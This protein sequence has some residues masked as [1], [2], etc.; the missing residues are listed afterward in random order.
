MHEQPQFLFIQP[1]AVSMRKDMTEHHRH[2]M[3]VCTRDTFYMCSHTGMNTA[4]H[5]YLPGCSH[6]FLFRSQVLVT[7]EE[8]TPA[9][10]NLFQK[11]SF[12][13]LWEDNGGCIV[14]RRHDEPVAPGHNTLSHR[15]H[16]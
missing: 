6:K 3:P 13:T 4:N 5:P 2:H 11:R 9:G 10:G 1:D 16:V 14:D 15:H 8:C 7:R 12:R